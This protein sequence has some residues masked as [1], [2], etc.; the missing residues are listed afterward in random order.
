MNTTK[1]TPI[2]LEDASE[3]FWQYGRVTLWLA[4]IGHTFFLLLFYYLNINLMVIFNIGSI[5]IFL[6][7]ILILPSKRFN[8]VLVLTHSEVVLHAFFAI[9]AIG[10]ESGFGYYILL[11]VV[12]NFV[13]LKLNA[14]IK[15]IRILFFFLLYFCSE[16]FLSDHTPLFLLDAS[17]LNI[18]RY[19]NII[20]F[21]IIVSPLVYY[22]VKTTRE[23]EK[24]LF[25]HAT[26][27]PLT[28]LHNRR[29][30]VSIINHEFSK[31]SHT[32]T[33]MILCD[34][35]F[36]KQVND[37]YGYKIG[38]NVLV[39]ITRAIATQ[40]REGDLLSRWGGEEFLILLPAT[41][42]ADA[43]STAERIR[44]AIEALHIPVAQ[45]NSIHVTLTLGV[46]SRHAQ[47]NFD[48]MLSRAETALKKGKNSGRDIV[49][50]G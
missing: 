46:V 10:I 5:F 3:V 9:Y 11:L 18:L 44:M 1:N 14:I 28:H 42:L 36:F 38:D 24:E 48:A 12:F 40:L 6:A 33:S 15:I 31:R 17:T 29:S 26:L 49:T 45:S 30:F 32:P 8:T 35:D 37:T 13:F 22:F 27:D 4:F 34:I 19:F 25:D 47:E 7:S 50:T 41:T 39:E 21:F 16:L 20:G 43:T 23:I 2:S